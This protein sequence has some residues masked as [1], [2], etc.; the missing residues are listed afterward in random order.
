MATDSVATIRETEALAAADHSTWAE[1]EDPD[2][3]IGRAPPSRDLMTIHEFPCLSSILA[4]I[5]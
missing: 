5:G 1:K 3:R 2:G 4:D